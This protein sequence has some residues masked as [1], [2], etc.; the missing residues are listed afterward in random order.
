VYLQ[1]GRLEQARS[2]LE[3]AIRLQPKFA[4]AHY[5]LALVLKKQE[6]KDDAKRELRA[7]LKADPQF[8][9][10]RAELDRMEAATKR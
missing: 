4:W 6:K 8:P 10:A 9:A 3:Q 2:E 5:N 1:S 7:A